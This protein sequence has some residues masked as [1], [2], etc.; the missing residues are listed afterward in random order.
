MKKFFLCTLGAVFTLV[1]AQAV[2]LDASKAQ[3]TW[4]AYKT[5]DKVPVTGSF[6]NIKYNFGKKTS[7]IA[8]TLEGATA[9]I[10]PMSADLKDEV[11]NSNIRNYFFANLKQGDIK[12]TF[13]KVIL[14]KTQGTATASV[15]MNGK[16]VNVPMQLE[17]ADGKLTA[18]GV[19]DI[20]S[21]GAKSAFKSLATQC[22]D[23]HSGLT[24]SQVEIA[25]SAPIDFGTPAK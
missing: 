2:T 23:L 13:R 3:T 16:T 24:W 11:K 20:L 12:V 8:K 21:F 17:I 5:A 22:H 4:T 7:D 25:F 15:H 1:G 6:E 10:D 14:G 18:K 9:I 19:L